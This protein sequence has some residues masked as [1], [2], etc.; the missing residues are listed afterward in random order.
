MK[1]LLFL[2]LTINLTSAGEL[3]LITTYC[4]RKPKGLQVKVFMEAVKLV[5]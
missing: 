4:I 1:S 3:M 2:A 5:V